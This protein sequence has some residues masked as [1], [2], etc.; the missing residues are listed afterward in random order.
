MLLSLKLNFLDI[1]V[2]IIKFSIF[3][4]KTKTNNGN[5]LARVSQRDN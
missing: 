3:K 5:T 1:K 4:I 2:A